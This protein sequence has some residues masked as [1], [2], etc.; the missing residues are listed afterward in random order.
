QQSAKPTASRSWCARELVP[1]APSMQLAHKK[2]PPPTRGGRNCFPAI[3]AGEQ[4]RVGGSL[5]VGRGESLRRKF[6][7]RTASSPE[8]RRKLDVRLAFQILQI[9]AFHAGLFVLLVV[10]KHSIA[11]IRKST[12]GWHLALLHQKHVGNAALIHR[13]RCLARR[14]LRGDRVKR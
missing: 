14:Q 2:S 10:L 4:F 8:L 5:R 13:V 11:R 3:V 12:L 6:S 7:P 9:G 1:L